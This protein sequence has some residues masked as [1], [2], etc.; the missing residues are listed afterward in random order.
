M[1]L[2]CQSHPMAKLAD[3]EW[4]KVA[5]FGEAQTHEGPADDGRF[6]VVVLQD[7][8]V[9]SWPF[10]A[11]SAVVPLLERATGGKVEPAECGGILPASRV[12]FPPALAEQPLL[13]FTPGPGKGRVA[14]VLAPYDPH[15]V[16]TRGIGLSDEVE[17]YLQSPDVAS[18]S[19]RLDPLGPD[20]FSLYTWMAVS[21][22][23]IQANTLIQ[24]LCAG[25]LDS[26]FDVSESVPF[27]FMTEEVCKAWNFRC[28]THEAF[29]ALTEE[30]YAEPSTTVP[31]LMP[32]LR[33]QQT[34]LLFSDEAVPAV[35]GDKEGYVARRWYKPWTWTPRGN[36]ALP[37]V[38]ELQLVH[39]LASSLLERLDRPEEE[40]RAA[41]AE[42]L[43]HLNLAWHYR[44][45]SATAVAQLTPTQKEELGRTV[46]AFFILGEKKLAR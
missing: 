20:K 26:S 5:V 43:R 16:Q 6:L 1:G 35:S 18:V 36:A 25:L 23:V 46:P 10:G 44:G 34:A 14:W 4:W 12:M 33:L 9:F 24:E 40:L 27:D 13:D 11:A 30:Q 41:L 32:G 2:G 21:A 29:A 28:L 45:K 19:Q 17:A 7:G 31:A 3:I 15:E 39:A 8:Q 42:I 22:C 38:R 37:M